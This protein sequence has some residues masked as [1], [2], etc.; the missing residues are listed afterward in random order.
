MVRR[1]MAFISMRLLEFRAA[2]VIVALT[3]LAQIVWDFIGRWGYWSWVVIALSVAFL[4]G[5]FFL[6]HR[7]AEETKPSAPIPAPRPRI[8]LRNRP[9]GRA[10]VSEAEFGDKLD[11]GIDNEGE[12]DASHAHF[13]RDGD[14]DDPT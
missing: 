10:D 9:G 12:V 2:A 3:G 4:I 5:T 13:G 6:P 1:A 14:S 7:K 11:V 8:G